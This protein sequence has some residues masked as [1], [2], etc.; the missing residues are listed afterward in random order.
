MEPKWDAKSEKMAPQGQQKG[1]KGC[2][3]GANWSQKGAHG[4]PKGASWSRKGVKSEPRNLQRHFLGSRVEKVTK[5]LW[6]G[7]GGARINFWAPF[8]AKTGCVFECAPARRQGRWGVGGRKPP[9]FVSRCSSTPDQRVGGSFTLRAC[10]PTCLYAPNVYA[11]SYARSVPCKRL[12]SVPPWVGPH[13]KNPTPRDPP[14][15]LTP[16]GPPTTHPPHPTSPHPTPPPAS[17]SGRLF[18]VDGYS[19]WMVIRV[20]VSSKGSKFDLN[21]QGRAQTLSMQKTLTAL[22]DRCTFCPVTTR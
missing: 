1:T 15:P 10:P 7:G 6:W 14:T 21:K 22:A 16:Q 2:Q 3:K 8:W 5:R 11:H 18:Q 13:P 19:K 4:S 12:V 9:P 20:H 17:P